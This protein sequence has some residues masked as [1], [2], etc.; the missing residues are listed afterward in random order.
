MVVVTTR[1]AIETLRFDRIKVE[2]ALMFDTCHLKNGQL[3]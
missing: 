2:L 3:G 1:L